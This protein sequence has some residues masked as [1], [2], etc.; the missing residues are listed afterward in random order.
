MKILI[1]FISALFFCSAGFS[2]Q[3]KIAGTVLSLE[4]NEPLA[5]VQISLVKSGKAAN[6][7]DS[8]SFQFEN[9]DRGSYRLTFQI[10]G[11]QSVVQKVILSEGGVVDLEIMMNRGFTNLDEVFILGRGKNLIGVA[12]SASEGLASRLQLE[13]RPILRTGEVM[14]TVPGLIVSQHSGSGKANQF[15]LR[16]LNLDH[17]TDFATS[18]EGM[19]LNLPTHAHGQGYLDM[20]FLI[21]EMISQID[22]RKGT[23]RAQDG[24]FASAGSSNI[25]LGNLQNSF[26]KA[27]VGVY[28]YYR[29][30]VGGSNSIGN[31]NFTYGAEYL[32]SEGPWENPENT[33]RF[34][35]TFK[36]ENGDSK[37]G[38]S[39]TSIL[40]NNDWNATDQIPQRA[41]N[42]GSMNRFDTVDASD[43]GESQRYGIVANWWNK[44]NDE[45]GTHVTGY[46]S[47][48]TLNLF[49]NF[50]YFLVNPERGDQFEQADERFYA[51]ARASHSWNANWLG[52]DMTNEMGLQFRHD[53]IF[54]VGL[55]NTEARERFNTIRSDEVGESSTGV[56]FENKIQWAEKFRS[57]FGLRG[58]YY[59]FDV[60]SNIAANSGNVSDFIASPKL[61]L[62]L[63]P[64][65]DTEF[66]VNVGTGFHS[67]DARGTTINLDPSSGENVDNVDPLV[68]SKGAELGLRTTTIEGLQSTLA[69]WYLKLDS[70]LV[71]V[72]DAGGTEA[73]DAS[74]HFGIE[75]TNYYKPNDFLT[76]DLDISFNN[77]RFTDIPEDM[78]RIPNSINATIKAGATAF[79]TP[80]W[81][82]GLRMRYFGPQPLTETGEPESQDTNILNFRT[83]YQLNKFT[84]AL[85]I[86]NILDTEDPDISYFYA[87]RLRGEEQALEDVHFHPALPRT[88]RLSVKYNF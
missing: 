60:D 7:N 47:Y 35:G 84:F 37:N 40:Y 85:N 15:Y 59:H 88:A 75:W 28:D 50:T 30:L 81:Y 4:T 73:S 33:N 5:D 63:G 3:G 79:I 44:N 51:G 58:D 77:S 64:W 45:I 46:A 83:A 34:S 42:Q 16:G 18:L 25:T 39:L 24:N 6:T 36:L 66:Y 67:N 14:E 48:Y 43:G 49:S 78:S 52:L 9:L 29:G 82:A 71:F 32:Y 65:N 74:R 2:Q 11:Y 8:G 12:A 41:L 21:T 19:P 53:N 56:Y 62:I 87:S 17:G 61:Q 22:F 1:I 72:G 23:Y 80:N 38:Y 69:L 68:R 57:V 26:V 13:T 86:L 20:N 31:Y 10:S 76:L 55:Y 70:E 27:E 54:E